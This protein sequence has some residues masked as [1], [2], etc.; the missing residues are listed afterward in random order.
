MFPPEP[1]GIP[2]REAAGDKPKKLDPSS[3][4]FYE[5]LNKML[6]MHDRKQADYGREGDSFA[7]VRA[8]NDFGIPG[9]L[10]AAL[11]LNDK[12]HRLQSFAVNGKLENEGVVDSFMD[13]A[14][15]AIIG[16]VL[17]EQESGD[18]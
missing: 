18:S 3:A 15:Y 8:S 12:V 2:G 4:R 13:I 17:W 14:V 1:W 6:E 16:L 7:N 11:R 5:I 10:G 9:W